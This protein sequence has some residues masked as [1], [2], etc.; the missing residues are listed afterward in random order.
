MGSI[1]GS[2]RSPG[3]GKGAS[4]SLPWKSHAQRSLAGYSPQ[5]HRVRQDWATK[6]AHTVAN[7]ENDR[8]LANQSAPQFPH[9][10][11]GGDDITV[12]KEPWGVTRVINVKN[13]LQDKCFTVFA[14][15]KDSFYQKW[16]EPLGEKNPRR[17]QIF[18]TTTVL[19]SEGVFLSRRLALL[20][21]NGAL[22]AEIGLVEE[23]LGRHARV[24]LA[25]GKEW[26]WSFLVLPNRCH[27]RCV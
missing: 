9:L 27:P 11:N 18:F 25:Q 24:P 26:L 5:G 17:W 8:L 15:A 21:L 7:G 22:V 14:N 1:P 3:E 6:H 23:K 20:A 16:W 12:S 10:K 13:S 2:G 19:D 4:V